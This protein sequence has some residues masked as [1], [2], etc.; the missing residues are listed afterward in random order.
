[1]LTLVARKLAVAIILAGVGLSLSG[2]VIAPVGPGGWCY[3]HPY[4]CR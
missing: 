1:M 3:Y 4:R 2:C